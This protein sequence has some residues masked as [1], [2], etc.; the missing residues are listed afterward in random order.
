[1]KNFGY[2]KVMTAGDIQRSFEEMQKTAT[3]LA[4]ALPP[5]SRR[6]F[7]EHMNVVAAAAGVATAVAEHQHGIM[8]TRADLAPEQREKALALMAA[9]QQ[10][11]LE[12][13]GEMF[14]ALGQTVYC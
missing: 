5:D 10:E 12:D 13:A 9:Y 8:L 2:F 7:T 14:E 4:M 11:Q 6:A 1:M 3:T